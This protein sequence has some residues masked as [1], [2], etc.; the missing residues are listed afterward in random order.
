M[1]SNSFTKQD[2]AIALE[3]MSQ[4]QSK[5]NETV[6][7][8]LLRKRKAELRALVRRVIKNELTQEEQLYVKLHWYDGLSQAAIAQKLEVDRSTVSRKLRHINGI[9]YEKLKYAMEFRYGREFSK[10][11]ELI[12]TSKEAVSSSVS[13]DEISKRIIALRKQQCLATKDVSRLTG[14]SDERVQKIEK[15][16]SKATMLELK[17]LTVLYRVS[18]DY[19][20]FGTKS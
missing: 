7:D 4:W 5:T 1:N 10:Q 13:D 16:G 15:N 6:D 3:A 8:L 12:I 20:I 2:R 19:I 9:I 11:S 14:I 18:S 17:K